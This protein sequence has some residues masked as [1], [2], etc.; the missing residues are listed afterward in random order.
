M[1]QWDGPVLCGLIVEP[2]ASESC[3][4]AGA[5][6]LQQDTL[7]CMHACNHWHCF[8]HG[9]TLHTYKLFQLNDDD[10]ITLWF[11][12]L[13]PH[14][15]RYRIHAESRA[16]VWMWDN[17]SILTIKEMHSVT[18]HKWPCSP[19]YYSITWIINQL[20]PWKP[21]RWILS[22]AMTLW[23]ELYKG[24]SRNTR[25]TDLNNKKYDDTK[26]QMGSTA[27][28]MY[29]FFLFNRFFCCIICNRLYYDYTH[30]VYR[31]LCWGCVI[32]QWLIM[33][34]CVA[35]HCHT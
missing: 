13:K 25:W 20:I 11:P 32:F 1:A 30:L 12:V 21:G 4:K 22:I 29:F 24:I 31:T 28:Y 23:W 26:T 18:C 10:L 17:C 15:V 33:A 34:G 9:Y 3:K 2:H 27:V 5:P 8:Q 19:L 35:V 16:H 6:C 14:D 7:A